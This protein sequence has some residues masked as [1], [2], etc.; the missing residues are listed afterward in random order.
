MRRSVVFAAGAREHE[1]RAPDS[2]ADGRD[3]RRV[4]RR[5]GSTSLSRRWSLGGSGLRR[6]VLLA[7]A[8]RAP[9]F[10]LRCFLGTEHPF[11]L[12]A[13]GALEPFPPVGNLDRNLSAVPAQPE[14][15]V[16]RAKARMLEQPEWALAGALLEAW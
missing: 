15:I 13:V 2:A 11:A 3:C 1:A 7:A 6:G 5:R 14:K 4:R 10:L 9:P 16:A 8:A 12:G